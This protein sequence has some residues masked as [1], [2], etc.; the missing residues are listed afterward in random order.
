LRGVSK[1]IL[2]QK[3]NE[4]LG[5]ATKSAKDQL[6]SSFILDAIAQAEGIKV[7]EHETEERVAQLAQRYRMTPAKLKA[8]L[9]ERAGLEE[10]EEQILVG[11]TLD[12]LVSNAKVDVV[13]QT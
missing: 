6:R 5:Y 13:P 1:E 2:E 4:I 3:K 10:I 9:A 12:F 8:Q 7:E 11:K